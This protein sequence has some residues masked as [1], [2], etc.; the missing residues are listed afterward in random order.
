MLLVA[1][2]HV[3][4]HP[5]HLAADPGHDLLPLLDPA[6]RGGEGGLQPS[7]RGVGGGELVGV[8]GVCGLGR[9]HGSL[10]GRHLDLGGCE[11]ALQLGKFGVGGG[12]AVHQLGHV[13]RGGGVAGFQLLQTVL[14]L[15]EFCGGGGGQGLNL[16]LLPGLGKL[17]GSYVPV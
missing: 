16:C 8:G 9:D 17:L 11:G 12:G 15:L 7:H 10:H 4:D 13:G 1:L 3:P 6:R 14:H 2:P 5:I